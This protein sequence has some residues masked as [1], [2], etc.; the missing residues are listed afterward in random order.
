MLLSTE[1]G[2]MRITEHRKDER[3]LTGH[4][5]DLERLEIL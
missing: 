2:I 4:Q 3:M 1:R 5:W